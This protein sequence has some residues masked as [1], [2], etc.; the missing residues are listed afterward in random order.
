[1]VLIILTLFQIIALEAALI[2]SE[3][4]KDILKFPGCAELVKNS[5]KDGGYNLPKRE[6]VKSLVHNFGR[7]IKQCQELYKNSIQEHVDIFKKNIE[8]ARKMDVIFKDEEDYVD[9]ED[10]GEVTI[11][12]DKRLKI[13]CPYLNC[14]IETVKIYRH[15]SITHK[16][17]EE[18][19]RYASKMGLQIAKN[20]MGVGRVVQ[21]K[22][23]AQPLNS[24]T[25][26]VARRH[27]YKVCPECSNLYKNLGQHLKEAHIMTIEDY[28]KTLDEAQVV[29][30]CYI[31]FEGAKAVLM[32]GREFEEAQEINQEEV[33]K[34]RKHLEKLKEAKVGLL[35]LRKKIKEEGGT[36]SCSQAEDLIKMQANYNQV[37]H[38]A[39][40][41]SNLLLSWKS[42]FTN[43]LGSIDHYNP[44]RSASVAL[45]F[46][47][48]FEV[49]K[50]SIIAY[51]H[52]F[53]HFS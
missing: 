13:K 33:E 15:L 19:C 26:L 43:H 27:N 49:Q 5:A 51:L 10:L 6:T 9:G 11:A 4:D 18:E 20:C 30:K 52:K 21:T 1:M 14:Q 12:K 25:C 36:P 3:I 23:K 7:N 35:N 48:C 17:S 53:T 16:L 44:Q 32:Q 31:K 47:E 37:R 24:S 40:A 22:T 50:V 38:N 8:S 2:H 46:L 34:Q 41:P 39:S 28:K 42:S 29:P 45:N